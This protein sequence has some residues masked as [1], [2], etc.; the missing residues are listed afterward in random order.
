M[1]VRVINKIYILVFILIICWVAIAIYFHNR[2]KSNQAPAPVIQNR[3]YQRAQ[4]NRF[5]FSIIDGTN[6]ILT[7]KGDSFTVE[8]KKIGFLRTSI[9]NEAKLT[10]GVIDLYCNDI[11]NGS[12]KNT[13]DKLTFKNAVSED[14][15]SS[16]YDYKVSSI[17]VSPVCIRLY[18]NDDLVTRIKSLSGRVRIRRKDILFSGKVRVESGKSTLITERLSFNPDYATFQT[19]TDYELITDKEHFQG[20]RFLSNIFLQPVSMENKL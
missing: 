17:R 12:V 11:L 14:T 10:N 18:Q 15:L 2:Q 9:L 19:N 7:I 20:N 16:I 13:G 1:N 8:K 4:I 5:T 3:E 6:K